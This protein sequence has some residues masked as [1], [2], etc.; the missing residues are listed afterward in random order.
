MKMILKFYPEMAEFMSD[1]DDNA[2]N[3][4]DAKNIDKDAKNDKFADSVSTDDEDSLG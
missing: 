3:D 4:K 1:S 2:E